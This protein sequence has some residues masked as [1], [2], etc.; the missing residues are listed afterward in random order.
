MSDA[1]YRDENDL[2]ILKRMIDEELVEPYSVF[3]FRMFVTPWP[4][5]CQFCY[6]DGKPIGVVVCKVDDHKS[7]R[8]RGYLGMIVVEKQ[9]RK[10]GIG[11]LALLSMLHAST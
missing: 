11:A 1:Q 4:Q 2:K 5:L 10:L 9:Y 8:R 3:T 6:V 7:G